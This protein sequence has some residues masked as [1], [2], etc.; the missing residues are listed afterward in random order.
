MRS[1]SGWLNDTRRPVPKLAAWIA[2]AAKPIIRWSA[3]EQYTT[4]Q[5]WDHPVFLREPL[6]TSRP[7]QTFPS[8]TEIHV[9]TYANNGLRLI[10]VGDRGYLVEEMP[11]VRA[12][13]G[14]G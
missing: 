3:E 13:E 2:V 12:I 10:Y 11:L 1:G 6:Q 9:S 7:S 8:G 5:I 4:H 14:I